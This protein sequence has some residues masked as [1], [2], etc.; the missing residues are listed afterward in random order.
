MIKIKQSWEM[1]SY[2]F[3]YLFLVSIPWQKRHIFFAMPVQGIFNEWTSVSLY[4]SDIFLVLLL[5]LWF[6]GLWARRKQK[7]FLLQKL[8]ALWPLNFLLLGLFLWSLLA[9]ENSDAP[10]LFWYQNI[11]FFF[12]AIFCLYVMN[13]IRTTHHKILTYVCIVTTGASQ[14]IIAILQFFRQHSLGLKLFGENDLSPAILGVAK[15]VVDGQRIIRSYGTFP[16]PNVL[17]GFLIP[18]IILVFLLWEKTTRLKNLKPK[19]FFKI[20][21]MVALSLLTLAMIFTFSRAAWLA[22]FIV[23]IIYFGKTFFDQKLKMVA[24]PLAVLVLVSTS[25]FYSFHAEIISRQTIEDRAGDYALSQR[26]F[27]NKTALLMIARHPFI[28]IGKGNFVRHISDY[29][30]LPLEAWQYQPV[31]NIYLAWAA[32]SGIPAL[33]IFLALAGFTLTKKNFPSHHDADVLKL[34][35]IFFAYLVIGFFD[36]YFYDLQ[37][38]ILIFWLIIGLIWSEK[39]SKQKNF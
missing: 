35:L 20:L 22:L 6:L 15:I 10:L 36:H 8:T 38:G 27:L 13:Q 30:K 21:L 31:H 23:L 32:D 3:F 12:I 5:L 39:F 7:N 33:L 25:S 11:R 18:C 2:F 19:Y 1:F 37:Q 28:G 26:T 29:T 4:L 14:A 17:A 9:A 16:H 24:L 34:K